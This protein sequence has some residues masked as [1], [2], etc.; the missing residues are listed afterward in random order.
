MEKKRASLHW[1]DL[2]KACIGHRW[3]ILVDL[4]RSPMSFTL[5]ATERYRRGKRHTREHRVRQLAAVVSRET[6]PPAPMLWTNEAHRRAA[7]DLIAE[8]GPVLALGPTANWP[9]KVWRAENFAELMRRIT[10]PGGFLPGA[11]VAVMGAAGERAMA[12]AVI[13]AIPAERRID[14]VGRVDLL[15][16]YAC[17]QRCAFYIGND[18][19]LMHVAAASG[20]PTLGLFGPSEDVFYAPWGESCAAIRTRIPFQAIFPPGFDHRTSGTL[21]DTL[22]VEAAEAAARDLWKRTAGKAT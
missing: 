11:R 8:D 1:L 17:L 15:T 14:L 20:V 13:D 6:D 21:M 3:D 19:G 5:R 2:W 10:G 12:Q 18:S 22:S 9:A 4:R 16:A 7:A